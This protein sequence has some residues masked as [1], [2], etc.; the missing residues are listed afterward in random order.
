MCNVHL[1]NHSEGERRVAW[2]HRQLARSVD[3]LHIDRKLCGLVIL[4]AR[5]KCRLVT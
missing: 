2:L 4:T 1:Q 3:W 5:K